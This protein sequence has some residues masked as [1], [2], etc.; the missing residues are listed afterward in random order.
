MI[1]Y[2]TRRRAMVDGHVR[3][4]DVTKYPIIAAMLRIPRE[5]FVP[6]GLRDL[7][8]IGD[9]V[10]LGG[11]RVVLDPRILAKTLD[12]LDIRP[13]ELVLDVGVAMGYSAAVI[14]TLA[15][16]VV[17]V[18]E[19]ATMAAEA[20]ALLAG[21]HADNVAVIEAPL[22]QGA[23]DQGPYDVVIVEGGVETLPQ[24]LLDQVKEGGRI[25]ALFMEGDLG[26]MRI[27]YRTA[28][29]IGWKFAFNADAPVLPGFAA[30]RVFAL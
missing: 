18:E 1:D 25:A 7:A 27:G 3:P 15:E 8:Y 2:P 5:A 13:D 11:G 26:E 23:P 17:A 16:A 24:S 9:H 19:D 14:S 28:G 10:Q 12:A 4:A 20:Q 30:E 21:H 22:A 6:D 29:R